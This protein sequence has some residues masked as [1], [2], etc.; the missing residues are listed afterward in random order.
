M[1]AGVKEGCVSDIV[2]NVSW[3]SK[4]RISTVSADE[5][6]FGYR[7][8]KLTRG[9]IVIEAT[10]ALKA[11]NKH[12]IEARIEKLKEK[13][14]EV[15]PLIWPSLGSVF[16]NPEKGPPAWQLVD[17]CNLRNVRVGGAR[18]ASEHTNWIINE[19]KATAKDVEVL[20]KMIKD[21][22]REKS[23]ISLETEIMIVGE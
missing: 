4:G 1:N 12:E 22:V 18:I 7:K 10:F 16:K 8:L 9:A 17:E 14:K 11:D 2:K 19:G 3:V 5:L 15:Q 20:V 23:D 13:R 6:K 21:H